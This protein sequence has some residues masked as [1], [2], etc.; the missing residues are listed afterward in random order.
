MRKITLLFSLFFVQFISAQFTQNE[1]KY[2]IGEGTK[3]VVLVADFKTNYTPNSYAWGYRF[4][5][6]DLTMEDLINNIAASVTGV[7]HNTDGGFISQFDYY[8]HTPADNYWSTWSGNSFESLAPNMG[9]GTDILEDGKFYALSF[10]FGPAPNYEAYTPNEPVAAYDSSWFD[11]SGLSQWNGQGENQA[12]VV[13]DFGTDNEGIADSFA[14][15]IQ[16]HEEEVTIEAVLDIINTHFE[17]F[18]YEVSEDHITHLSFNNHSGSSSQVANWTLYKG[19]DLASW[20]QVENTTAGVTNFDWLG[21]SYEK[22]MPFSPQDAVLNTNKFESARIIVF[23]NPATERLFI[24]SDAVQQIDIYDV[25]G[26]RI[27]SEKY[28]SNGID[29][30]TLANGTYL[31]QIE[32]NNNIKTHRFIKR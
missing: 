24:S 2:W 13:I 27:K 22:R 30:S 4:S 1:V 14:F 3:S 18:D 16:F 10:G 8:H 5:E 9:I 31:I 32:I 21:F 26:K 28:T 25:T 17:D 29:V 11:S 19:Q 15:G 23:P 12:V 20:Y 7:S 6:D